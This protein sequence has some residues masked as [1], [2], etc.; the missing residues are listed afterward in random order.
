MCWKAYFIQ[1]INFRELKPPAQAGQTIFIPAIFHSIHNLYLPDHA[2]SRIYTLQRKKTKRASEHFRA[3]RVWYKQ[4]IGAGLDYSEV[5]GK[6]QTD[7]GK[8][9]F[10]SFSHILVLQTVKGLVR[11]AFTPLR[12]N[13]D[14]ELLTLSLSED[15]TH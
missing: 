10:Y 4:N 8:C 5:Q 15:I 13:K 12:V 11:R 3:F 6:R 7:S 14:T 9:Y 2:G 1:L